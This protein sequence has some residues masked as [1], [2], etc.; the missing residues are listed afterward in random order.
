MIEKSSFG[1][2][3]IEKIPTKKTV[4]KG[5]NDFQSEFRL[6][7]KEK[8]KNEI[9]KKL[10]HIG[11]VLKNSNFLQESSDFNKNSFESEISI[12][13]WFEIKILIDY[14]VKL[15]EAQMNFHQNYDQSRLSVLR[16]I[17]I[18]IDTNYYEIFFENRHKHSHFILLHV[19]TCILNER[20]AY[21]THFYDKK[22]TIADVDQKFIDLMKPIDQMF[23]VTLEPIHSRI[24]NDLVFLSSLLLIQFIL[25][26][27]D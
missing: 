19:V 1:N 2:S 23:R 20:Q 12:S 8:E 9:E 22:R 7:Q 15:M 26:I 5:G 17:Q 18:F 27:M 14:Q 25:L 11:S 10:N 13:D 24:C 6:L 3:K 21:K 16:G 4:K